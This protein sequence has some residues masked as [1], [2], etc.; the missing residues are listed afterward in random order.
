MDWTAM[1]RVLAA[2]EEAG[3]DYAIVG[4]VVAKA[5]HLSEEDG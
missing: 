1:M 3:V 2:L 4:A 5:F